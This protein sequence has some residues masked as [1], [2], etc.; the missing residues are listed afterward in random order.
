M[1]TNAHHLPL[2][3]KVGK[4]AS[5]QRGGTQL[6]LLQAALRLRCTPE[7][8]MSH[9]GAPAKRYLPDIRSAE[10]RSLILNL[11]TLTRAEIPGKENCSVKQEVS[12]QFCL[13]SCPK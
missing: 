13:N 8:A 12:F 4:D 2:K 10:M 6:A 9:V 5:M 3:G 11:A 1:E 7:S